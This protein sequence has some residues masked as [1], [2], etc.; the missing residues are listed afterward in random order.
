MLR[1]GDGTSLILR[2]IGDRQRAI[3]IQRTAGERLAIEIESDG[4]VFRR[5][6]CISAFRKRIGRQVDVSQQG[7][8]VAILNSRDGIRQGGVE[9]I[10][11]LGDSV[12][13]SIGDHTICIGFGGLHNYAVRDIV[14]ELGHAVGHVDFLG[15]AGREDILGPAAVVCQQDQHLVCICFILSI[16]ISG[17]KSAIGNASRHGIELVSISHQTCHGVT[18]LPGVLAGLYRGFVRHDIG[19]DIGAVLRTI[20]GERSAG[21]VEDILYS[22][23]YIDVAG[24]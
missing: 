12:G 16:R 6:R 21:D 20:V 18:D 8:S 23:S 13:G 3:H 14:I 2:R 17:F 10:A 24:I 7:H 1:T 4:F 9:F 19:I 15:H 22:C 5:N 11:D